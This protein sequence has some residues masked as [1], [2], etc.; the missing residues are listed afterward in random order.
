MISTCTL[1]FRM[2]LNLCVRFQISK[3]NL[4]N[5]TKLHEL[6]HM[7]CI[8]EGGEDPRTLCDNRNWT[9]WDTD[10]LFKRKGMEGPVLG[11]L[12]PISVLFPI[13]LTLCNM[14]VSPVIMIAMPDASPF[15]LL[16]LLVCFALCFTV[17][18]VLRCSVYAKYTEFQHILLHSISM[19][20]HFA[21][22]SSSFHHWNN[23]F[24][25]WII[26]YRPWFCQAHM[27]KC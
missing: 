15:S 5:R 9:R 22:F 11:G 4:K 1:E 7:H 13:R 24:R 14:Q 16:L 19:V 20:W 21:M 25:C 8:S 23:N 26:H 18:S 6:V 17:L 10:R 2:D 12:Q 3:F 27:S